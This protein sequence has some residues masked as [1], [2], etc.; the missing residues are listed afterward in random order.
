MAVEFSPPSEELSQGDLFEGVP[1]IYVDDLRYLV[2]TGEN[3][4]ALQQGAQPRRADRTYPANASEV[5]SLGVVVT[6]DCEIDKDVRKALVYSVLVRTL[7][8][9][10]VP[11][12]HL[13]G[14]RENRRHRAFY[15]PA[16]EYL[17]GENYI[18]FRRMTP[19]RADLLLTLPKLASMNEDGKRMLQEHL[20]RFLTRRLLPDGWA[21]WPED[22]Q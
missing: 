19:I 18:D 11:E 4:F 10:D 17:D 3:L 13:E 6:H 12:E 7:R 5:R 8:A 21:G 20:F 15:L 22:A 2:K 16:N 1:S 14:F 9:P